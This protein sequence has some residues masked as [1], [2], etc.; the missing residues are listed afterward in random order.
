MSGRRSRG[1]GRERKRLLD[2][3]VGEMDRSSALILPGTGQRQVPQT[4]LSL[5][6]VHPSP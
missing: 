2:P 3:P 6:V 1:L 5:M 4:E